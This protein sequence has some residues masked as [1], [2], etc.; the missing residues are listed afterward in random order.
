MQ[1]AVLIILAILALALLIKYWYIPVGIVAIY[2]AVR[3]V[4]HIRMERYFASEEF[5]SKLQELSAVVQEHNDISE[6][7]ASMRNSN[8]FQLGHSRTGEHSHL[9]TYENTSQHNYRRDRHVADFESANVHNCSLQVVR[10]ASKDPLKYLS[11][12]FGIKPNEES[13]AEVEGLGENIARL[14]SAVEN[15]Q[16]RER[17]ITDLI[18]PPA[19]I[20]KHYMEQFNNKVGVDLPE[21]EIPYPEYVFEYTSAGGN[22]GQ[23]TTVKLDTETIDALTEFL[24]EKIRFRAS[25]AGQRALMTSK[26]REH[27]KQRDH[28]TC[29]T[30]S[31][32]LDDEPHLLLEIDHKVPV[33]KG[34]LT[35]EENLQ[36]L[37]WRC[38]R[39]KSDKMPA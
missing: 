32:S 28:Y 31:V 4:R 10:N 6:Y 1:Y 9:A 17:N 38:N 27:I 3:I 33:S 16:E 35:T 13:L 36:T 12:Y 23:K 29:Q 24:S 22:S 21:I 37:C 15:L 39:S 26:L 19:F 5:T 7:V 8:N 18:S 25:A 34:G 30:C 2:G 14:E 20:Q 11:K